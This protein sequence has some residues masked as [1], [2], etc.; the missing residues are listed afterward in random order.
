M[1]MRHHHSNSSQVGTL[2]FGE[3]RK[4]VKDHARLNKLAI[5]EAS[6]LRKEK[7]E[8]PPEK[9]SSQFDY[10]TSRVMSTVA[11]SGDRTYLRRGSRDDMPSPADIHFSKVGRSPEKGV[12]PRKAPL[13]RD[14]PKLK[15]REVTNFV[16]KNKH[17][18]PRT[19]PVDQPETPTRHDDFGHVPLYL[20]QRKA[21]LKA[22]AA[23]KRREN[24]DCPPGMVK[25]DDAERR[26]MLASLKAQ[27]DVVKSD[28]DR[29]PLQITT[30]K[31]KRKKIDLEARLADLDKSLAV[32]EK[33][34]VYVRDDA[35]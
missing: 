1:G 8:T 3:K 28:L 12:T 26:S 9:R 23:K 25:M 6:R 11:P 20:E 27:H 22:E 30:L 32:F 15:P 18:K 21:Q 29:M 10:V 4:V 35:L 2:V 19:P 33:P 16:D 5:R 34:V 24:T 13:P 14:R 17:F 7:P 31:L